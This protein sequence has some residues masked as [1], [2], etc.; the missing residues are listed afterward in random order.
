MTRHRNC[1]YF[2]LFSFS[3]VDRKRYTPLM[4]VPGFNLIILTLKGSIACISTNIDKWLSTRRETVL[5]WRLV[6]LAISLIHNQPS[7][8]P[9]R[10]LTI[11]IMFSAVSFLISHHPESDSVMWRIFFCRI[12]ILTTLYINLC[13]CASMTYFKICKT[14]N[15]KRFDNFPPLNGAFICSIF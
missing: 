6:L 11:L 15:L 9:F 8:A 14:H 10:H 7:S 13:N 3:M 5:W 2:V 4:S 1:T 12:I